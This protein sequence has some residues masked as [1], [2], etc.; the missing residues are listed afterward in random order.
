MNVSV[1]PAL[2]FEMVK[3]KVREKSISHA[4]SKK[5][6]T[7]KKDDELEKLITTKTF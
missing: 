2:L 4:A 5:C 6:A 3:L 1:N 7:K